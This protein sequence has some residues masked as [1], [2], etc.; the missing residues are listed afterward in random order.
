MGVLSGALPR[1]GGSTSSTPL[2]KSEEGSYRAYFTGMSEPFSERSQ[3]GDKCR[4]CKGTG[5]GRNGDPQGC[6]FCG[7]DGERVDKYVKLMYHL[8][9]GEVEE[10]KV[11]FKLSAPGTG[12]DG[13]PL[14]ASTLF[15]RL[16]TFSGLREADAAALDVWYSSIA[17]TKIKIPVTV[18]IGYNNSGDMLKISD[19]VGR[20]APQAAALA[21]AQ[22]TAPK[23]AFDVSYDA[24]GE[25]LHDGIPF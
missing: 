21:A 23:P 19:V 24:N 20:R 13:T 11:T 22:K 1:S 18:N 25:L 9:T 10:E 2:V 14:L 17:S 3:W 15:K 16:R 12:K 8:E 4:V 7:G 6:T 5:Q